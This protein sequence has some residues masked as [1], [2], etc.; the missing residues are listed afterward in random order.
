VP[1]GPK[2]LPVAQ[3]DA[4]PPRAADDISGALIVVIDDESAIVE[5]MQVLLSSWGAEVVAS[6]DGDDVVVRLQ[7][8]GRLP[9]VIIADYRLAGHRVGTEVIA[10]L[11]EELDPA[12]PAI[13]V[14]G[15]ATPQRMEEAVQRGYNLMLKPVMP[16]KLRALIAS[17]LRRQH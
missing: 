10:R 15:S 7:E 3:P 12:I 13:M 4:L 11:H 9:D 1:V 8:L 17:K 16:E 14:T 2:P 5:G 6:A